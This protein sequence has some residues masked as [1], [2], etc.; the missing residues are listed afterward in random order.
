[1]TS[2]ATQQHSLT[3]T[4]IPAAA[5]PPSSHSSSARA[6]AAPNAAVDKAREEYSG[7]E[8]D[9]YKLSKLAPW[10][11]HAERFSASQVLGDVAGM[12]V[13][14]MACG[15]GHYTRWLKQTK[16]AGTV[17]GVDLSQ[18]MV[19]LAQGEEQQRPLGVAYQCSNALEMPAP[20]SADTQY[21]V[22]FAAFLLNY[23]A[24][25][26]MLQAFC[27]A[28][29]R[30]LKSGGRFVSINN[31]P[32]DTQCHHPE[33]RPLGLTKTCEQPGGVEGAPITYS[34]FSD[35]GEMVCAVT[36]YFL[37]LEAHVQALE[38]AGFVDV[39]IQPLVQD[40]ARPAE[41]GDFDSILNC[42]CSI[43]ATKL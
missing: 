31:S 1:M 14:D 40:P 16:K 21:D 27:D 5:S 17:L 2:I 42:I 43:T 34:F 11:K 26:A 18:D 15:E 25:E 4:R 24:D 8:A 10:R 13:L 39:C 28:V 29:A 36:N 35:A 9:G 12:R 19:D 33:L 22:V 7:E 6:A 37:S 20:A 3:A 23:A 32:L 30:Q 41:S 38:R